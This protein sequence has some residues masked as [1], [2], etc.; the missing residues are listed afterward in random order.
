MIN[1]LARMTDQPTHLT[2]DATPES[3][4]QLADFFRLDVSR[5]LDP[6]ALIQRVPQ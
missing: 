5:Q 4:D 1:N 3:V 2:I 6:E